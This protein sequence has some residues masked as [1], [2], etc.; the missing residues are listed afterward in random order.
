M[1][2][3]IAI[4]SSCVLV[5]GCA[6][7]E[8]A[9]EFVRPVQL[10]RVS[11]GSAASMSVFAGE[12][13][14]RH[15]AD[16]AFRIGGK[17]IERPVDVGASVRKGQLLARLDPSDVALQAEAAQAAV[18]AARTEATFAKAE[19]ERFENLHRQKFV[20]A[21]ALD[22]KR[23]AMT[24][25]SARL[26]QAQAQLSVSR[27][28]AG[29]ASLVAPE[30][31][32]ITAISAEAG[33][34]IASAQSVMRLARTDE[35]E[36]AI[37]VPENRIG[38]IKAAPQLAA[39]LW[40]NP[41]KLYKARV[42]E[43]A[44]SVDPVTRTFAVRV[45]VPDADASLGWGM[46]ANVVVAGAGAPGS[47]LLPLTSVYHTPEGKPAVWIYDPGAQQ[48]DLRPVALGAYREDGV[49]VTAGVREGEWVVAAGV[50]KLQAGQRVRPY[51][52][53]GKPRPPLPA[54]AA[55]PPATT[56]R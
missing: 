54:Q 19:F 44:P 46:T 52:E 22:Q 39:V 24:T 40:A 16:L 35:R 20:S 1:R 17:L 9:V 38:E 42:R 36:I 51:E 33:Q 4:L 27:N 28:Q 37:A 21:S 26:D 15:E 18:A 48:V 55:L 43:I 29:Y 45:A 3:A 10:V 13:K 56:S 14:P 8:P 34:V 50:N 2:V 25:A 53:P 31:G 6:K 12:V 41:G 49:L 11:A 32:V 7:H 30:D 23:N 5:A 47:A